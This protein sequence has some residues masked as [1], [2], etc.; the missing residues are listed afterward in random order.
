MYASELVDA[1]PCSAFQSA[2]SMQVQYTLQ[3]SADTTAHVTIGGILTANDRSNK[4]ACSRFNQSLHQSLAVSNR[5]FA[6]VLRDHDLIPQHNCGPCQATLR[7]RT[8]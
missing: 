6:T 5:S 2:G 4:K 3:V 8:K 7:M 1:V